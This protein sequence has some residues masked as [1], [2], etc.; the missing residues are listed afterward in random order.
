MSQ[1]YNILLTQTA[2]QNLFSI[3]LD[4]ER[5]G[6]RMKIEKVNENQIRCTLTR[7]DLASREL[8]LSELAY[9]T[10]KAKSLFRDMMQQ[11]NFEFGFEAEDIPLMIE[12]IPL[13][14]ECIVLIITKVE[15]PEELDTRFSRFAPSSDEE[16]EEGDDMNFQ[17]SEDIMNLFHKLQNDRAAKAEAASQAPACETECTRI[18]RFDTLAQVMEA[19]SLITGHFHGASALFKDERCDRYLLL[20]TGTKEASEEFDKTCNVISEYGFLQRTVP[21]SY[22]FLLEHYEALISDNAVEALG[23]S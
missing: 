2:T 9:G 17:P 8:K 22:A 23:N 20:L 7:E 13:N 18:F 1:K 10:E 6:C 21:C 15:D 16:E 4:A 3:P 11:A 12:A 19:A 5:K 14:A